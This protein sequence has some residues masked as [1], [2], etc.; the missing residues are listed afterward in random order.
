MEKT[1]KGLQRYHITTSEGELIHVLSRPGVASSS[2]VTKNKKFDTG[3]DSLA[4]GVRDVLHGLLLITKYQQML[5]FHPMDPGVEYEI[6]LIAGTKVTVFPWPCISN[7][8]YLA[9][10]EEGLVPIAYA[11]FH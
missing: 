2:F 8:V 11:V 4:F 9:D 5:L 1:K 3:Y 6:L 10:E 7:T